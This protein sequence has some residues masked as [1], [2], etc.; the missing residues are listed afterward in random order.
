MLVLDIP[1]DIEGIVD[2]IHD[3]E[4]K[5]GERTE[6][7][8]FVSY[9]VFASFLR[10]FASTGVRFAAPISTGVQMLNVVSPN[11]GQHYKVHSIK[12]PIRP[13][14]FFGYQKGV[15]EYFFNHEFNK[16]LNE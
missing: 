8:F 11:S 14:C 4:S 15:E 2:L 7:S 13:F 10:M 3:H 16:I 1:E 6:A 12:A 9:D 5:H